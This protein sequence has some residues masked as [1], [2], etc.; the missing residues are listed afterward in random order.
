MTLSD[1]SIKRPVF[2]W[3]LM[4]SLL[5][6]GSLAFNFI[7]INENPD[8]EYPTVTIRYTYVGATPSVIEKDIIEPVESIL[9]SMEGIREMT[10]EAERGGADI[11][12]EFDLNQDIDFALQE[13]NT[14]LTRAQRDIPDNID[15]PVVT[16]SNADD[17]PIMYGALF[18]ETLSFRELMVLFRDRIR[19]RVSTVDG[20]AE[21]RAFGYHEPMLRVDLKADQ[22]QRYRLTATDII[23]SIR[24][25]HEELPAGRFE[26][27]ETERLLRITG[28][29]EKVKEFENM[30]ISRRGGSPN[31]QPLRLKDVAH[32]YEGTENIRRYARTNGLPSLG[33][34]VQKQRGV[35]AVATLDRVRE[36]ID[37]INAE[38]PEGTTLQVNFDATQ[39]IKESINELLFTLLLSAF[40]TSIVCWIFIGSTSASVN[41]LL[42]IPTAIVGT[43]IFL[44]L[45]GFTL[46]TFT[47]LALALAIG[48]VVD[49]AIVML[50][51]ITRYV[52]MGYDRVHASILGAREI[53][54]AVIA[55]TVALI[56]IFIPI[57][58]LDGI[59]GRFF[60]E[61]ALTISVA[62]AL[63]SLEALTLAPMR[64]SQFL[65]L[66][67]RVTW[68]GR[69]FEKAIAG[70][71]TFYTTSLNRILRIKGPV[72]L[73][74][75]AFFGLSLFTIREIPKE[76]E[77][78]QDR[79]VL[80]FVFFTPEGSALTHTDQKIRE[81]EKIAMAHPEIK[82]LV[83]SVGGFGQGGEG[84]LGNGV[85][86]LRDRD[87]RQ[88]T[89]FEVATDLRNAARQLEGIQVRIRDRF[90]SRIG[91]R[92][93]SPVEF[94]ISGPDAEVQ[95]EL[96]SAIEKK[97]MED[98]DL[99]EVRSNDVKL[100]PETHLVP[101]R[102]KAAARGVEITE[103][104]R[105]ISSSLGGEV[106]SQYTYGGRRFDIYVQLQEEDRQSR[107]DLEKLLI[108]NNRGEYLP[109]T[110]VVRVENTEGP[111]EIYRED[112]I[113]G[114]RVDASLEQ[115]ATLGKA[116]ERIQG[117][118]RE[119]FPEDYFV[120]F[121]A[122]PAD[123]L[124]D[125][126]IIMLFGLL[127]GYLILAV[128]FNSF[129]DPLLV[130]LAVPFAVSGALLA[131]YTQ[132]G[133]N[134]IGETFDVKVF[135]S[136]L[137]LNLYSVIGILLTL[138]IVMK[139]SI[140]LVEFTNKLRDQGKELK[141]ALLEACQTRLRPILMTNLATLAAAIPPAL[142]LGPGSETRVPM[143]VSI[144]GGVS[145]SVVFT[146]FVVPCVYLLVSPKRKKM[147]DPQEIT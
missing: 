105:V 40:L 52:R 12:I 130:Y 139:N 22:L 77:P 141:E 18:S 44:Y 137:T 113:R 67:E 8:V 46:N 103:I 29:A 38:L 73:G 71:T 136:V 59:E 5:F 119:L 142:A 74:A 115:G 62:V 100:T 143:A 146:V 144:L 78:P 85:A 121:S 109:L 26:T 7:G 4:F 132:T 91:G 27:P 93:G 43:F 126:L 30:V 42:A 134:T 28:E 116:V 11:R 94:T 82:N 147:I 54:F 3:V 70:I 104:A 107:E 68:F 63:S 55:T 87:V 97:M 80:F 102:E 24:R 25:E 37:Q 123:K 65:K 131:L 19:D 88:Q 90:G 75:F 33:F 23:E 117:W 86:I 49:D 72:V 125:A 111:Q 32:V 47:V 1:L 61:F 84:N 51:N 58:F 118:A 16:K 108:R 13:I 56:S 133:I 60:F 99:T 17:D 124:K 110:E 135:D 48:V 45:L 112:R 127:V 120:M 31:F 145:F 21:V 35:N 69:N 64:C 79:G 10:S 83:I 95:R 138:G 14:L 6:F 89:Q 140:L 50:E 34:A 66:E 101:D 96:Y 81:F 39:F 76:I 92:R 53:S 57:T 36:R 20:V 41:V 114:V 98:P 122:A 106:A 2:A 129:I 128:Q 9:V 15:P